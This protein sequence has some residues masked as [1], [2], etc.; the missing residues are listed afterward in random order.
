MTNVWQTAHDTAY[1]QTESSGV[2]LSQQDPQ[3]NHLRATLRAGICGITP[4]IEPLGLSTS[5]HKL[6]PIPIICTA[7]STPGTICNLLSILRSQAAGIKP[8]HVSKSTKQNSGRRSLP[9]NGL[10]NS[11]VERI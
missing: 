5:E 11:L 9:C 7:C 3:P 8:L 10:T 2:T 6:T 4:K 1:C